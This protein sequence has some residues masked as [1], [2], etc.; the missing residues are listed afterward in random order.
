[1]KHNLQVASKSEKDAGNLFLMR[2]ANDTACA[3]RMQGS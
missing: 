3:N 2:L 1:M